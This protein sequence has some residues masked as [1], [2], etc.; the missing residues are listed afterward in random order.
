MMKWVKIMITSKS[1]GIAL[2]ATVT[3]ASIYLAINKAWNSHLLFAPSEYRLI[4]RVVDRLA[5]NN[6]LPSRGITFSIVTGSAGS[7]YAK[8][9]GLCHE[10][11][12]SVFRLF[13]PYKG[14]SNQTLSEIVRISS[15]TGPPE[16]YAS[17]FN[18]IIIS[19]SFFRLIDSKENFLACT[20][21]HELQHI[22]SSHG[23][24]DSLR[25]HNDGIKLSDQKRKE[26][27]AQYKRKSE[28]A[29]DIHGQKMVLAAGFPDQSCIQQL[30]FLMKTRAV[31]KQTPLDSH[32]PF[33][34]RIQNLN[35]AL[36]VHQA[37]KSIKAQPKVKLNWTY[38]RKENFLKFTMAKDTSQ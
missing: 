36:S 33:L 31:S 24:E 27:L 32:P 23:Y 18:S 35:D 16:A 22:Y 2:T 15:F 8:E 6:T 29:A 9:T 17:M 12:C 5:K 1:I 21:S 10:E 34:E 11:Y 30:E 26:L 13:S 14:F 25:A 7:W 38:N 4:H 3:T 28:L 19:R 37:Q 20:L